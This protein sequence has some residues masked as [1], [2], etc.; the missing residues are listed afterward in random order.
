MTAGSEIT[1]TS[2]YWL[3]W[4]FFVCALSSCLLGRGR[5]LISKFEGGRKSN[6]RGRNN[7]KVAPGVVY[8]EEAW[9][10]CLRAFILLGCSV[11]IYFG[12]NILY[13]WMCNLHIRMSKHW[14]QACRDSV[15]GESLDT[16]QGTNESGHSKDSKIAGGWIYAFQIMYQF[17][18]FFFPYLRSIPYGVDLV[19]LIVCMHSVNAVSYSVTVLNCFVAISVPRLDTVLCSVLVHVLIFIMLH[20]RTTF[21]VYVANRIVTVK[22]FPESYR[23]SHKGGDFPHRNSGLTPTASRKSTRT[24]CL[25]F[26]SI[27]RRLDQ[28]TIGP[29]KIQGVML[30]TGHIAKEKER[31]IQ[32][33]NYL[34]SSLTSKSLLTRII[35]TYLAAGHGG[36]YGHRELLVELEVGKDQKMEIIIKKLLGFYEDEAWNTCLR[37][38]NPAW[39]LCFRLF[40]FFMLLAL[41]LAN[42][43]VD[44]T[45]IFYFYTRGHLLW[46]QYTLGYVSCSVFIISI[47][48]FEHLGNVGGDRTDHISSDFEGTYTPPIVGETAIASNRSKHFDTYRSPYYPPRAGAWTYAFQIMYQT[49]AG[50]VILTD[51]VFWL[52]LF[53]LLTAKDYSLNFLLVC[54]HSVNV[55]FLVG[56]T[57]LNCMPFPFFRIGYFV[58]WTGT[59]VVFQWIIHACINLWWPY[60]FL[61]LSSSYAPLWYAF[62]HLGTAFNSFVR[63]ANVLPYP[64]L[65][66]IE[67]GFCYVVDIPR[68]VSEKDVKR[69]IGGRNPGT[70]SIITKP[71]QSCVRVDKNMTWELPPDGVYKLN[72]DGALGS[73]PQR[74]DTLLIKREASRGVSSLIPRVHEFLQRDWSISLRHVPRECNRVVDT[75][76]HLAWTLPHEYVV[77][78][79]PPEECNAAFHDDT[80]TA[81]M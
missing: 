43:A 72:T 29:S 31:K 74:Y 18:S 75:L 33:T 64:L 4:R 15:D 49:S 58:L 3:N 9:N 81:A 50:A 21:S 77:F 11:D 24:R 13:A 35:D 69:G 10:T 30:D 41:L 80:L 71:A 1:A 45:G 66:T 2:S 78:H 47:D 55:V 54:M 52:I 60:P 44:G 17:G 14:A 57:I 79:G 34:P 37:S 62:D 39:L 42:V 51:S 6:P 56:D 67:T 61:D 63:P 7:R 22:V 48:R 36:R 32:A 59:F 46:S 26:G 76:A 28:E 25:H 5:N 53:P 19:N 65:C 38:I 73:L 70:P 12:H 68:I 27:E 40:A 16:E 20:I 23:K 8:E